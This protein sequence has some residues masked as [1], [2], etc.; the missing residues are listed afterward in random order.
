M[1][2]TAGRSTQAEAAGD[3][4]E[5][6]REVTAKNSTKIKWHC[7]DRKMIRKRIKFIMIPLS[8]MK[9]R[10]MAF[11]IMPGK[12]T[13]PALPQ[14]RDGMEQTAIIFLSSI[15]LS[16][17]CFCKEKRTQRRRDAKN[18]QRKS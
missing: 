4:H 10:N 8:G 1:G 13:M 3:C 18:T 14:A 6:V 16:S 2:K 7:H 12:L 11:D 9:D 17:E 15:F 5:I